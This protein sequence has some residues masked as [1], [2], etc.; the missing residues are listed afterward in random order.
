VVLTI[1]DLIFIGSFQR[2][3]DIGQSLLQRGCLV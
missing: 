2:I 3:T 1:F